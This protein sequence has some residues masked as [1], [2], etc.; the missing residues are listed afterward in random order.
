MHANAA[1]LHQRTHLRQC[2][3]FAP[4]G[5]GLA[6]SPV[7]ASPQVPSWSQM[8]PCSHHAHRRR[9]CFGPGQSVLKRR[10]SAAPAEP[11]L[12]RSWSQDPEIKLPSPDRGCHRSGT[13]WMADRSYHSP[14]PCSLWHSPGHRHLSGRPC[15]SQM[16]RS[17]FRFQKWCSPSVGTQSLWEGWYHRAQSESKS[18]ICSHCIL[19]SPKVFG[20]AKIVFV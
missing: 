4:G 20:Q 8:Q 14:Q 19:G 7:L 13:G 5:L 12:Q 16:F 10:K 15:L 11:F 17:P 6:N 2:H 1:G 3:Q 18:R 9:C